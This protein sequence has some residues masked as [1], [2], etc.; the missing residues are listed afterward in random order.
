MSQTS[1]IVRAGS[2]IS[3]SSLGICLPS[4]SSI[5]SLLLFSAAQLFSGSVQE[6]EIDHL[7]GADR[8]RHI[9]TFAGQID[10]ILHRL[11]TDV[12]VFG[13]TP[14][15]ESEHFTGAFAVANAPLLHNNIARG[16][17]ITLIRNEKQTA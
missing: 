6:R 4:K 1:R 10:E 5:I 17:A 7:P 3:L 13:Q 14:L 15:E 8:L 11:L 2:T 12:G 9:G 16:V